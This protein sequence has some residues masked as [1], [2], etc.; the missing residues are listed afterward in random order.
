MM[1]D[2][3]GFE[4]IPAQVNFEIT[5]TSKRQ[6]FKGFTA[7]NAILVQPS[8]FLAG[9]GASTATVFGKDFNGTSKAFVGSVRLETTFVDS[10]HLLIGIPA[11]LL[12]LPSQ[13][14]ITVITN[15]SGPD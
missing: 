13:F 7:S 8:S 14:E 11:F 5:T 3:F 6:D 9:S 2:Q 12:V 4:F 15:G 1:V 10:T